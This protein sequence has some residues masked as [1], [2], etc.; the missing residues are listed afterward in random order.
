MPF[1]I[2]SYFRDFYRSLFSSNGTPARLSPKR[3][4]LLI[5]LFVG[6][7]IWNT[8]IRLGLFLDRIFYPDFKKDVESAPVFII[9]NYRSGSTFFHRLL[10]RDPQFTCMKAWEIYFAPA[11]THRKFIRFILKLSSFVGSPIQKAVES[12]DRLMNEIYSMH[13]TGLFTFEQDSQLFYHTWSS[14]NLFAIFPFPDHVKKYIYYD[15]MV[16]EREQ[17]NHFGYYRKVLQRHIYLSPGMRY[18]SKNPDFTPAVNTLLNEFP[19]A[20]FINLVRPPEQMLPSSVNL[21][22]SNWKAYGTPRKGYPF[23]DVVKEYAHHWYAY[24]HQEL[25]GLPDDQYSVV[26]F[27][28]LV[29]DPGQEVA[30]LYRQFGLDLSNEFQDILE[31]ETINSRQFTSENN[32]S[33][34]HMDLDIDMIKD[35]F[36]PALAVY[37]KER[38]HQEQ[39]R[40]KS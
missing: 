20:K 30:R 12:F 18:L 4:F 32:Y 39:A 8:Y 27:E 36:A 6:F 7:P 37:D 29:D 40:E 14:F 10:L 34:H 21:W 31:E 33:L 17:R 13:E 26:F 19:N 3:V 28:N 5:F 2:F 23:K 22:A 35:E 38:N 15:Q 24:P 11:I 1:N 25:S 9:G 16:S